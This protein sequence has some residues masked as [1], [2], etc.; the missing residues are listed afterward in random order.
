M[1]TFRKKPVLVD[2]VQFTGNNEPAGVFREEDGRPYVVTIHEQRCYL[3]PSDWILPEPDGVHFY[4]VKHDVFVNTYEPAET[5]CLTAPSLSTDQILALVR[6]VWPDACVHTEDANHSIVFS[7]QDLRRQHLDRNSDLPAVD[8]YFRVSVGDGVTSLYGRNPQI[9][10][11][12][13][14]HCRPKSILPLVP[15]T[16]LICG[17]GTW[18]G[19]CQIPGKPFPRTG[20]RTF[21]SCGASISVKNDSGE[22]DYL[23]LAKNCYAGLDKNSTPS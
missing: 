16:C 2:A 23:I 6:P 14:N 1:P 21:Y 8:L 5:F 18:R 15:E 4:P 19:G 20:L 12:L 7:S 17:T 13:K 11:A 3:E 22:G 9:A 10:E